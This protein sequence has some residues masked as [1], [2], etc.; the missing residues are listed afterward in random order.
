MF[1]SHFRVNSWFD[2]V[3]VVVTHWMNFRQTV[4]L[5]MNYS[6]LTTM[7]ERDS[8]I[9]TVIMSNGVDK[10]NYYENYFMQKL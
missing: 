3:C 9:H 10:V 8:R 6:F 1:I 2:S 7:N 4:Y 5:N